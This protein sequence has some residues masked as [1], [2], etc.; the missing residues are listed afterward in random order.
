MATD[1]YYYVQIKEDM[2]LLIEEEDYEES[3]AFPSGRDDYTKHRL[4]ETMPLEQYKKEGKNL[5]KWS[6]AKLVDDNYKFIDSSEGEWDEY[7]YRTQG[8]GRTTKYIE[9]KF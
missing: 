5:P 9:R 3:T 1:Y 4:L 7:Q 6:Q 8:Y 2:A